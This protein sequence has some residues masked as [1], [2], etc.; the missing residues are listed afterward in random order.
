MQI[1]IVMLIF[2]LFSD[3]ILGVSLL[4]GAS[5]LPVEESQDFVTKNF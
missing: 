4:G 1:S 2:I 5:L 3:Q